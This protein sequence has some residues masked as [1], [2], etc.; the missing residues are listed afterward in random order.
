MS[1]FSGSPG[2]TENGK[3]FSRSCQH[4]C[5]WGRSWP[6]HT[7]AFLWEKHRLWGWST[8]CARRKPAYWVC[9]LSFDPGD[10]VASPQLWLIQTCLRTRATC[11]AEMW[12]VV[13]E[14]LRLAFL[15]LRQ[16]WHFI[17][18]IGLYTWNKNFLDNKKKALWIITMKNNINNIKKNRIALSKASLL[19]F[20]AI[21]KTRNKT[22]HCDIIVCLWLS[23]TCRQWTLKHLQGLLWVG[24]PDR[25][26]AGCVLCADHIVL[27]PASIPTLPSCP[28]ARWLFLASSH[29]S[30]LTLPAGV[31][32]PRNTGTSRQY[33]VQVC[34]HLSFFLATLHLSLFPLG[35][36]LPPW[37]L[38]GGWQCQVCFPS[39]TT[40]W[41]VGP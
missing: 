23:V 19:P 3:L 32:R 28:V 24:L 16:L 41:L 11:F 34:G 39:G 38:G 9:V 6:K 14:V 17:C 8:V 31:N 4:A 7:H 1:V 40:L 29:W 36:M 2:E 13:Q 18:H 22:T 10:M 27:S 35:R 37:V 33:W 30:H 5:G 26:A 25:R 20:Q 12:D 15:G 21:T